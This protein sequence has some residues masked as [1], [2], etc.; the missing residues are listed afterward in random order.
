MKIWENI[1][2]KKI[3]SET[4]IAKSHFSFIPEKLT[5]VPLI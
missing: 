5:I 3:R 1:I 2:K 4:S